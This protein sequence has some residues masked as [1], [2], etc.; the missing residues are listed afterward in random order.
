MNELQKHITQINQLCN[1]HKVRSLFAFGSVI[2]NNFNINSDIDLV[3]D[4]DSND[5]LDY[6]DNYF[7]VK[8]QLEDILHRQV[9][10]LEEKAITNPLLKREIDNTKVLIYGR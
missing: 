1:L 10:L 3:V 6:S 9:D 8:F 7:A 4:I 5:P 2:T